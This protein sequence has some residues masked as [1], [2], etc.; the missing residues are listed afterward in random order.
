MFVASYFVGFCKRRIMQRLWLILAAVLGLAAMTVPASADLQYT[1]NCSGDPCTGASGG[2]NFGTVTLATGAAGHV[3]VTVALASA[4]SFPFFTG[5][6]YALVWSFN[7]GNAA[8]PAETITP[9]GANAGD[10]TVNGGANGAFPASPFTKNANSCSGTNGP[11][12]FD[13]SVSHDVFTSDNKLVLDVTKSGGLVLSNFVTNTMGYI[14]AAEIARNDSPFNTFYVASNQA[15]VTVPE[16]GTLTLS[17]AG[18]AG[19]A[20]LMLQRR[21]KLARAA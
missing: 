17:I 13:Y 14:F 3:T 10:F 2:Q 1:L 15:G 8:T 20:G 9:Q 11:S 16:P 18:L 19:L 6:G 5:S 7:S 12:C 4:Y 21:R